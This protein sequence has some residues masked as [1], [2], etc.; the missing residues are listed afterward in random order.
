[1]SAPT[2]GRPESLLEF[3]AE[4]LE[5]FGTTWKSRQARFLPRAEETLECPS[6]DCGES[7]ECETVDICSIQDCTGCDNS[8]SCVA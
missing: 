2:V 5:L 6:I 7:D 4:T 3:S 8:C 1:M